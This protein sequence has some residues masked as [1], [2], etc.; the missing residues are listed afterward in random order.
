L[1][2]SEV[3]DLLH[4]EREVSDNQLGMMKSY[5]FNPGITKPLEEYVLRGLFLKTEGEAVFGMY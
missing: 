1:G 3:S 5:L 4:C 2:Q